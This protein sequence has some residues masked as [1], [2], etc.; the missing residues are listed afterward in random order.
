MNEA[1]AQVHLAKIRDVA[2]QG[3]DEGAHSCEESFWEAVLVEIS[4]GLCEYPDELAR[5]ALQSRDI[6][7]HRW[8]A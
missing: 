3:D 8:F 1:D 4:T 6:E 7:F 5:L 2:E